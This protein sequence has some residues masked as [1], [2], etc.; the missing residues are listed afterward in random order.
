MSGHAGPRSTGCRGWG[1]PGI[2][3]QWHSRAGSLQLSVASL[4]LSSL[5][6]GWLSGLHPTLVNIR[7]L[8][9]RLPVGTLTGQ[10]KGA[11]APPALRRHFPRRG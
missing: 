8:F 7:S 1:L 6:P 9:K 3:G 2:P 10:A 11:L 5:W 4:P